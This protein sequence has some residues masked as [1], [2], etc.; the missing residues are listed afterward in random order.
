M[1]DPVAFQIGR[2]TIRWYGVMVAL[3]FLA[4][5]QLVQH[6]GKRRGFGAGPAGDLTF[7]LMLGGLIGARALYVVQNWSSEFSGRWFEALRIDHG[8]LVFYGGFIGAAVAG[9]V[10]CR[11][12]KWHFA[13][14]ADLVAP[15]LALGH[16]L[17]RIGCLINGCCFGR[18]WEGVYAVRY[19]VSSGVLDVH[20]HRGL[21]GADAVAALPVFPV[22][23]IAA[24]ANIALCLFLLYIEPR[25]RRRGQLFACY[26]VLYS[27]TRFTIEYLR[28][29]YLQMVGPFTPAQTIC[30][31][32]FPI[33]LAWS[34]WALRA[35]PST[36]VT[37][38]QPE[39]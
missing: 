36:A 4:A 20:V 10:M 2:L 30:L 17:G 38:P 13:E 28:G 25:M 14:A 16:A 26:L 22:Q 33:G 32:L 1:T 37:T 24:V 7:V 11:L 18:P 35:A 27:A 34:I 29:D 23:L 9:G 19:P 6:R 3:G 21:V 5:F 31:A 8:G 39:Q 12:R 15:A